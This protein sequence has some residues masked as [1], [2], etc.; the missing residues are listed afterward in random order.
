MVFQEIAL[1][2]TVNQ[3][4]LIAERTICIYS[5]HVALN[6]HMHIYIYIYIYIYICMCVYI[7]ISD[8]V[9]HFFI[10]HRI[11]TCEGCELLQLERKYDAQNLSALIINILQEKTQSPQSI[12]H[13]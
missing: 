4:L 10:I 5:S 9:V 11:S 7:C 1:I 12:S 2:I 3:F 6:L 8:H 13:I